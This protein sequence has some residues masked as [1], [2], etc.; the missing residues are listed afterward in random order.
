[1]LQATFEVRAAFSRSSWIK[2]WYGFSRF[3]A[4][5]RSCASSRGEMRIA[6]SRFAFPVFGRPTRR[7]RLSSSF[8][9]SGR[10]ENSIRSS[11]VGFTFFRARPARGDDTKRFFAIF[12]TPVGINQNDGAA[13]CGD[14]QS[15]EPVLL[16][17]MFQ[18]F[19]FEGIGISK[20]SGR[21]LERD[22]MLLKI[23][24]GFSGIPGER[25]LCI[26]NN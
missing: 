13:L 17:G 25:N 8:V 14:P 15:L 23:P 10:S 4:K 7:A 11:C 5:R 3:A 19:P 21:F 9:D 6:I 16:V 26:Y 18:V 20:N 1:L 2:V 24:G 12:Q 22:A